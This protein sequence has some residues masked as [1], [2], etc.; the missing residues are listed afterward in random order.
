MPAIPDTSTCGKSEFDDF[1][2]LRNAGTML[3][4]QSQTRSSPS[5]SKIPEGAPT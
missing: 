2:A 3:L 1:A 5:F 4:Y